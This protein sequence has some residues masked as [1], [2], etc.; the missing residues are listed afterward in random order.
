MSNRITSADSGPDGQLDW[1]LCA[2]VDFL[3]VVSRKVFQQNE[4]A[5]KYGHFLCSQY[6]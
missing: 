6:Y 1:P 3:V 2:S 4:T 5:F